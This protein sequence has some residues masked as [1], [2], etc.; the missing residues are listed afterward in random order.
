MRFSRFL[1]VASL[2]FFGFEFVIIVIIVC[3]RVINVL[4]L[5]HDY[6]DWL[7]IT[8]GADVSAEVRL[9]AIR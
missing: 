1:R 9:E 2:R 7:L 6:V 5:S 4:R 8:K 3:V